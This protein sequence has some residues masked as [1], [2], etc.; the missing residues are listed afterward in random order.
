MACTQKQCYQL[1]AINKMQNNQT[2][3][4]FLFVVGCFFSYAYQVPIDIVVS[5]RSLLF[6]CCRCMFVYYLLC[7]D[8][9]F[10][11][12]HILINFVPIFMRRSHINN[13]QYS[14]RKVLIQLYI[15][16][17]SAMLNL[18]SITFIFI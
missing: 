13:V 12:F 1:I 3:C 9:L 8:E 7:A 6:C 14:K 11:S 10:F 2:C 18:P 4:S 5:D 17:F 16:K 15:E